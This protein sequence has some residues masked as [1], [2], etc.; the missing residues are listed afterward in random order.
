MFIST[1]SSLIST[2]HSTSE[3]ETIAFGQRLGETLEKG[4]IVAFF[5]ELGTGKT[6]LIK[7][8]V[9]GLGEKDTQVNSP[10][11]SYLNIYS[12]KI[13]T[14]HFDLYRLKDQQDFLS[15]GF[16]EYFDLDGICLIEWAEK[17]EPLL[18]KNTLLV[19]MKHFDSTQRTISLFRL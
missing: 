11:F 3:E 1:S 14:Y 18:P 6:T 7:G 15:M 4:S 17:I 16:D 10:T 19:Q 8:I 5:G 9:Q 12:T 2:L 13:K